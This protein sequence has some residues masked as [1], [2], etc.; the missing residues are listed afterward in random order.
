[1]RGCVM[2]ETQDVSRCSCAY[3][4]IK[5]GTPHPDLPNIL[6]DVEID[7]DA[8]D[9]TCPPHGHLL[10]HEDEEDEGPLEDG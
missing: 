9:P 6:R 2:N 10:N 4:P 7:R 3:W 5:G 8:I 1:M